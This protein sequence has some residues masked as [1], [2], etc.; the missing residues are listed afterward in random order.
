MRT[1]PRLFSLGCVDGRCE[2]VDAGPGRADGASCLFGGECASA[3]CDQG[4]CQPRCP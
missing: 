2:K 4:A 1:S 3:A